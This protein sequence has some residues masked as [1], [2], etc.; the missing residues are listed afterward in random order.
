M[1]AKLF[2]GLK[3]F[4]SQKYLQIM[5]IPGIIWLIIFCYIPMYGILIAFKNYQPVNGFFGGAWV[6][7]QNFK[8]FFT[9]P[10]AIQSITNTLGIS[11]LKLLVGFPAPII[12]ALFLNELTSLRFKKVTQTI[13]YLP[14]FIS[15]VVLANMIRSILGMQGPVNGLLTQLGFISKGVSFMSSPSMYWGILVI[16]DLW[17]GI[18]WGSIIYI[19][20]IAGINPE[21][22]ESALIDGAKRFQ[23]IRYITLPCI[24]PTMAIL[25]ILSVSGIL[26][27]NFE[28]LYL[29]TN[30][31]TAGVG[32]VIDTYVYKVGI[33]LSR[34]SYATAVGLARSIVSFVLLFIANK[35][36]RK[37]S[38]GENGLFS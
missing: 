11:V 18:G 8:D 37:L 21:L 26:G 27:S 16:S 36:V 33:S 30:A 4:K 2:A 34:Y 22:Y 32:E 19:A 24:M 25:I 38:N 17:K 5:V 13:S 7:L 35:V 3:K 31:A 12:F 9:D 1:K 10:D 15:W 23:R 20:A 14:Y 29:L 6:G 28:Q